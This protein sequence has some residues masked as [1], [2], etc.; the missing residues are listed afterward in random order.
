[1]SAY[2][3]HQFRLYSFK[4]KIV[5]L[6]KKEEEREIA[7]RNRKKNSVQVYRHNSDSVCQNCVFDPF[8]YIRRNTSPSPVEQC[9]VERRQFNYSSRALLRSVK[10][11]LPV[12]CRAVPYRTVQYRSKSINTT[13]VA[14]A[15]I[16]YSL[17]AQSE[18]VNPL[19]CRRRF[20]AIVSG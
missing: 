13:T 10:G 6:K 8:L 12:S 14:D 15:P 5:T 7:Q 17:H 16:V 4:G 9:H 18:I 11:R 20:S 1:M 19:R 3:S 2:P